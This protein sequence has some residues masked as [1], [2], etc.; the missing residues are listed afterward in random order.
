MKIDLKEVKL[1]VIIIVIVVIVAMIAITYFKKLIKGDPKNNTY[2]DAKDTIDDTNTSFEKSQYNIYADKI[3]GSLDRFWRD[4]D[5]VIDVMKNMVTSDDVK[6]LIIS[7]GSRKPESWFVFGGEA[8]LVEWITS[9]FESDKLAE[10]N[11]AIRITG[12]KF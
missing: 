7:F 8:N 12:F 6:A 3:Q 4:Y 9:S 5:S 10:L 2:N 1:W 11:K